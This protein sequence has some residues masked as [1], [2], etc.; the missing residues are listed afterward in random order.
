MNNDAFGNDGVRQ[1]IVPDMADEDVVVLFK[2][3]DR[4]GIQVILDGGWGVDALLGEQTR[5][6]ADLDIVIAYQDVPQIRKILIANGYTD[7]PRPDTRIVNFVMGDELGHLIDIHTYTLDR[8]NHPE[9]G[10]DYPLESLNGVGSILGHPVR[11]IDLENMIN[12]HTGYPLDEVDYHD[13]KALCKRFGVSLPV[14][15]APFEARHE[16]D[17]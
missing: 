2:L 15:Y 17:E 3:F 10:L 16:S 8:L 9:H 12:F 14:E 5:A 6:H 4:A 1:N 7:V 11:C 13:V